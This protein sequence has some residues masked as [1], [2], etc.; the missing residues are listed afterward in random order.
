M[1]IKEQTEQRMLITP[2]LGNWLTT[3]LLLMLFLFLLE[4]ANFILLASPPLGIVLLVLW[5]M[6][7]LGQLLGN[8]I[9]LDKGTQSITIEKRHFLLIRT[10]RVIPF[11]DVGTVVID[12]E[13][14][15]TSYR[16]GGSRDA[17]RVSIDIVGKKLSI[18]RTSNKANMFDLASE[19]S[20]FIG[21][22]QVDNSAKPEMLLVRLFDK[23]FRK[24]KLARR[25]EA[26]ES[27]RRLK[28]DAEDCKKRE[29]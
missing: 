5:A 9:V 24:G 13:A 4:L 14:E 23:V 27:Y 29:H 21:T 25:E 20:S 22:E 7:V 10:R 19:I 18:D 12:Y 16:T 11:S 15:I 6:F 2:R 26:R 28:Q 8:R 1:R 17:W 3:A